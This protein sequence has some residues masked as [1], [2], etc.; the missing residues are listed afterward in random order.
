MGSA[1]PGEMAPL[2][3]ARLQMLDVLR[4]FA[5]LGI[6]LMNVEYFGRPLA[7]MG[8]GIDPNQPAL[9]YA[10]S[11]LV[12]V[13]VQGKFWILFSLLFGMGFAL[14]D[15]RARNAGA[16]FRV[17]HL[18]RSAALLAIGLAHA[19]L[20]WAGDILVSYAIGAFVLL[21]FRDAS[22]RSQGG[23][24][25][26]LYGVP[27]L[28]LVGLAL[29]WLALES[30]GVSTADPDA[31][32]QQAREAAERAAET[33]AYA[34]GSWWDGTRMRARYFVRHA[35]EMAVFETFALGAFLV[36]AWLLRSGAIARPWEHARL[37]R[38]LRRVALPAGVVLALLSTAVSVRFDWVHDGARS[39]LAMAL[40]LVASPLL[41]LGY[42]A[43]LVGAL[44]TARGARMLAP[45]APAGRMA[46]TNYL[47][48][49]IVGTLLFYGFGLGLWGQVPRRWQL[50]GALV[51]FAL[52]VAAS[53]WWLA[54]FRFGPMEWLWRACTYG[55]F[56]SMRPEAAHN[57]Y[58]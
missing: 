34:H 38:T 51:L 10:L 30:S 35:S 56:S 54:R 15:E 44:Q 7:D 23:W 16:D 32:A 40:M 18:R 26:A 42:L 19:L 22:P 29:L 6:L 25:A 37:Y 45:L 46:L 1:I 52:Q 41:S 31:V 47:V 12:Y 53:R 21:W 2:A 49:S 5:L 28:G 33:A 13:F 3:A 55:R 43:L 14:M 39:M 57:P 8:A 48:Q 4:G 58:T 20:V 9:D 17:I 27:A 11:W 50:L 24:G 36:G